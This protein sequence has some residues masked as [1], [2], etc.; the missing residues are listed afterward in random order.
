[1]LK[2]LKRMLMKICSVVV[3]AYFV[4]LFGNKIIEETI[5]LSKKFGR[6]YWGI[7]G[8]EGLSILSTIGMIIIVWLVIKLVLWIAEDDKQETISEVRK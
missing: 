4:F 1:M 8:Y 3:I 5:I 2:A 7:K 6:S